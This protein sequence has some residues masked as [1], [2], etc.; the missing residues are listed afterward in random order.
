ME[1][2]NKISSKLSK[3]RKLVKTPCSCVM[4]ME[5]LFLPLFKCSLMYVRFLL[6]NLTRFLHE[7]LVLILKL[8]ITSWLVM[9][10]VRKR[11]DNKGMRCGEEPTPPPYAMFLSVVS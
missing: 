9:S 4:A 7:H 3:P 11:K 1:N 2:L 10:S 6:N 5:I 8:K